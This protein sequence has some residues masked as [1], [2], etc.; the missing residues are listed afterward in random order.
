MKRFA[1]GNPVVESR[2]KLPGVQP[3]SRVKNKLPG[4]QPARDLGESRILLRKNMIN[5]WTIGR[6]VEQFDLDFIRSVIL[7][8]FLILNQWH[9]PS[10]DLFASSW[11]SHI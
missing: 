4:G 8:L 3:V 5:F 2:I 7:M 10:Y 9:E 1:G 6:S 11:E